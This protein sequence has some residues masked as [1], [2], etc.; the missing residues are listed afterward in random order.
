MRLFKHSVGEHVEA[1]KTNANFTGA[2]AL[3]TQEILKAI[4]TI[5][6]ACEHKVMQNYEVLLL[7]LHAFSKGKRY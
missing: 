7:N 6:T 1:K 3:L 2:L 5:D 4:F